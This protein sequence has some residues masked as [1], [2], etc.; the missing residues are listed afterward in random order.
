MNDFMS[1][2]KCGLPAESGYY[3]VL[4]DNSITEWVYFSDG[5]FWEA[6]GE[7]KIYYDNVTHYRKTESNDEF[8]E[9]PF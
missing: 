8:D 1:I 6:D 7:Y 4:L 5:E 2:E 3:E 9:V